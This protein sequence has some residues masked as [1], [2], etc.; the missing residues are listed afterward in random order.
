M[1][2]DYHE[3]PPRFDDAQILHDGCRECESRS[4]SRSHGI[5][6][7]DHHNFVLAWRRA[8][9]WN[10]GLLGSSVVSNAERPML[11]VLWAVQVQLEKQ[12]LRIGYLPSDFG[13]LKVD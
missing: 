12:G 1:S 4:V 8:A 10:Q 2:H 5:S 6:N 9:N 7:L 11:D 3:G 13:P